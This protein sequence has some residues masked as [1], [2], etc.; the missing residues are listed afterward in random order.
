MAEI[1]I[2]EEKITEDFLNAN[3]HHIKMDGKIKSV[4]FIGEGTEEDYVKHNL[5]FL[6]QFLITQNVYPLY[7]TFV[8][9]DDYEE[10]QTAFDNLAIN[11][12]IR[13]LDEVQTYW[14]AFKKVKYHPPYF[15]VKI[16]D[17]RSL[18]YVLE[19]TYW[20]AAS[21]NEFYTISYSENLSFQLDT[22][23]EWGKKRER[24]IPIFKIDENTTFITI[25]HDG[26]GFYLFTNQE[27]YSTVKSLCSNL[28]KGTVIT[29]I[30]DTLIK[31]GSIEEE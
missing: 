13:F 15:T 1:W 5:N 22:V 21:L 29:Q 17:S 24:S 4:F 3:G 9:V 19:E 8:C 27:K 6:Q 18:I 26:N 30:N 10:I 2:Q 31:R 12:K 23:I 7:L 11:Y 20:L 28:P 25:F 14:T 16:T